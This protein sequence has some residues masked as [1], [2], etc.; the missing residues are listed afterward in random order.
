MPLENLISDSYKELLVD[1]HTDRFWGGTGKEHS[2]KIIEIAKKYECF[3]ALDYGSSNHKACL[4]RHFHRVYPGSLLF[5]EYDPGVESKSALPQPV[6]MVVCTDVL[7]HIEPELLDNVLSHMS[8]CM[9][10]C[11]YLV[12][13]N[14]EAL[15]VLAD[16][17]NAHLIIEDKEWW[18]TKLSEHF[19]VE[20]MQWQTR[21]TR[22]IVRPL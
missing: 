4:K 13:S 12:I 18:K 9:L 5:Y 7:E 22:V 14:V 17:R 19:S 8:K 3:D 16:G 2:A 11:G 6:D 20:S 10:K 15:T 21:E 1:Q